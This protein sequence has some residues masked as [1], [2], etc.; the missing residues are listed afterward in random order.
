[1]AADGAAPA[2]RERAAAIR[3]GD[4]G[5]PG[6]VAPGVGCGG[7]RRR[8]H[9]PLRRKPDS[10]N[11]SAFSLRATRYNSARQAVGKGV[12]VVYCV[13]L[14][15]LAWKDHRVFREFGSRTAHGARH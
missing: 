7:G 5:S 9:R 6:E 3:D 4:W 12:L 13:G 10:V 14:T 1:M 2:R 11:I 8:P 15:V